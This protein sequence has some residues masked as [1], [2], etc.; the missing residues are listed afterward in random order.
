MT[1]RKDPRPHDDTQARCDVATCSQ[2]SSKVTVTPIP[3]AVSFP[4]PWKTD[5]GEW[6]DPGDRS[7]R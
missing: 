5:V 1:M 4:G 6:A 3:V 2:T 7:P